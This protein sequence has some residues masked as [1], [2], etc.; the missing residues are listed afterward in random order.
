MQQHLTIN[1]RFLCQSLTGV[2]R[3]AREIVTGLDSHL[4]NEPWRSALSAKIVAPA[5][6]AEAAGR[7]KLNAITVQGT[8][9]PSQ[10]LY[11]LNS[12]CQPTHKG[13]C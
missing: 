8:R 3:Y 10:V 6:A 11:G 1:G 13:Y 9:V 4:Q 5:E 12:C 2:Q 7:L